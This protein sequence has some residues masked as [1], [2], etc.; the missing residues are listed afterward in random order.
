MGFKTFADVTTA[1]FSQIL[2][3]AKAWAPV[4]PLVLLSGCLTSK[5]VLFDKS[6]AVRPFAIGR[7][8]T[9]KFKDNAWV[10]DGDAFYLWMAN[11]SYAAGE[12]P[13]PLAVDVFPIDARHF[14]VQLPD[15]GGQRSY[16]LVEPRDGKYLV[17][18]PDCSKYLALRGLTP[19]PHAPGEPPSPYCNFDNKTDL[20]AALLAYAAA[21]KPSSRFTLVDPGAS[22]P[23]AAPTAAVVSPVSATPTASA[24]ATSTLAAEDKLFTLSVCNKTPVGANFIAFYRNPHDA[25]KWLL[26]GWWKVTAGN[27]SDIRIPRGYFYISANADNGKVWAGKDRYICIPNRVV[28]RV[29]FDNEHCLVG[30]TNR[31]F[32]EV[33]NTADRFTYNLTAR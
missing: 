1:G 28:E 7:Y 8:K 26:K 20:E 18:E 22:P 12:N 25:Q 24:G 33:F 3:L 23:P 13:H 27:C 16:V 11:G 29:V 19:S 10:P 2:R 30:E 9:E 17:Y 21:E 31:G 32:Y 6:E 14:A 5:G 4:A 15:K